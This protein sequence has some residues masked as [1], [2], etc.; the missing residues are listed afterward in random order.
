MAIGT[1]PPISHSCC[2]RA[3]RAQK[4]LLRTV[5]V[6]LAR[7]HLVGG[8]LAEDA[9]VFGQQYQ[10]GT[11]CARGG[12][13]RLDCGQVRATS[14]PETVCTAATRMLFVAVVIAVASPACLSRLPAGAGNRASR[15]TTGS[16]QLPVTA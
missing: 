7:I 14:A 13:Q 10:R 4:I 2:S 6:G 1:V 3:T 12:D 8:A 5:A 16:D 9:E 11:L 15:S